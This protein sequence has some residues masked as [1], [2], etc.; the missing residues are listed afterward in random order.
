MLEIGDRI[1]IRLQYVYTLYN[2]LDSQFF[3]FE[4]IDMYSNNRQTNYVFEP[5]KPIAGV[6]SRFV[7]EKS[8]LDDLLVYH[9]IEYKRTTPICH[10]ST[11]AVAWV[12]SRIVRCVG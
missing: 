6:P 12:L 1:C 8:E 7:V 2:S 10:R 4:M 5:T 9:K 11:K 3:M